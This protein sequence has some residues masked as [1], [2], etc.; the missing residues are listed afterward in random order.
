VESVPTIAN[1]QSK[2][3]LELTGFKNL[4]GLMRF[5]SRQKR[6]D[7]MTKALT[8]SGFA[9]RE[10]ANWRCKF[11]VKNHLAKSQIRKVL[12]KNLAKLQLTI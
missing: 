2:I 9:T 1:R 5:L 8:D 6:Q 11:L 4:V 7:G 3:R 10:L 12:H